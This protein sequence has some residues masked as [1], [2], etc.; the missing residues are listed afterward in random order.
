MTDRSILIID[1]EGLWHNLLKRFLGDAGYRVYIAAT[2]AEGIKLAEVHKPDCIV[3]DFHLTDGDAVFVCSVL[4]ENKDISKI[5]VIIFS[6][7]PAA[8][9]EAYSQC[10]AR[11]FV[12]KGMAS[13]E[14]LRKA[15]DEVLSPT[16]SHPRDC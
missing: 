4:R 16:S 3:L 5:P 7:D 1:D 11:N 15:I 14:A 9:T 13:L 8:E 6:S 12:Y 10:G 2:C